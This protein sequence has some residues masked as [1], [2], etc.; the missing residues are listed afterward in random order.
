MWR[1][2]KISALRILPAEYVCMCNRKRGKS[3]HALKPTIDY[4]QKCVSNRG[5][6]KLQSTG[7][8]N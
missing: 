6:L 7:W 1:A 5:T 4:K 8:Q 2:F 3:E